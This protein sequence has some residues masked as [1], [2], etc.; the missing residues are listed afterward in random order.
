MKKIILNLYDICNYFTFT[1]LNIELQLLKII[2]VNCKKN[3]IENKCLDNIEIDFSYLI[4][5]PF[6]DFFL[7]KY[8]KTHKFFIYIQEYDQFFDLYEPLKKYLNTFFSYN[9]IYITN[10][11]DMKFNE[12]IF[13]CT[14][15]RKNDSFKNIIIDNKKFDFSRPY[16]LI[17]KIKQKYNIT[18][19]DLQEENVQK[20]IKK[21]NYD[22]LLYSFDDLQYN[23]LKE[24]YYQRYKE[25]FFLKNDTTFQ[26]LSLK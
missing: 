3:N 15:D 13:I 6:F 2:H 18:E 10:F 23:S 1:N 24:I 14:E 16:N 4:I 21:N 22:F 7:N 20:F 11:I 8:K 9:F 25:L 19:K 17:S 5:R 26:K 12:Y